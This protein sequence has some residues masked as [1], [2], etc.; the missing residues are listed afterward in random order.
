[1]IAPIIG[2]PELATTYLAFLGKLLSID[3]KK[4][5]KLFFEKKFKNLVYTQIQLTLL[6]LYGTPQPQLVSV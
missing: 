2:I 5:N 4:L 1:M 6:N 3:S